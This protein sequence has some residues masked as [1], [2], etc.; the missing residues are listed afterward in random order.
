MTFQQGLDRKSMHDLS[1]TFLVGKT[2]GK[3][4]QQG[5]ADQRTVQMK[6]EEFADTLAEQ[7]CE[8]FMQFSEKNY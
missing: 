5:K 1:I 6:T 8:M 2:L 7:Q 4:C 3:I